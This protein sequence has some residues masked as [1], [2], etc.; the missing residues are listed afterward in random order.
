MQLRPLSHTS[1][2]R[3]SRVY[4]LRSSS[5][6]WGDYKQFQNWDQ[7]DDVRT[8]SGLHIGARGTSSQHFPSLVWQVRYSISRWNYTLEKIDSSANPHRPISDANQAQAKGEECLATTTYRSCS[9]E[10][11]RL[12]SRFASAAGPSSKSLSRGAANDDNSR[13]FF[14]CYC[15]V[16]TLATCVMCLQLFTF[17]LLR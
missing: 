11:D 14:D 8:Y 2:D 9:F 10:T 13:H 3:L 17:G 16:K 4:S 5:N 12:R 15:H 1:G 7:T 6:F